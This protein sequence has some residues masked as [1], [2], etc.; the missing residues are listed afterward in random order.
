M[1][2]RWLLT[3]EMCDLLEEFD[4]LDRAAEVRYDHENETG[5]PLTDLDP[6]RGRA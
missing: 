4:S 2:D 1:A 5:H 6:I 3:C